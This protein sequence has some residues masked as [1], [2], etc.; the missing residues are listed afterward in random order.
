M[1]QIGRQAG[2]FLIGG[3]MEVCRMGYGAMRLTGEGVWGP[4][5]DREEA[6][7]VLRRAIELG[8]DLI[9]TADAYGPP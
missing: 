4:P 1:K 6:K 3:D 7:R 8:I 2:T 9:D 5:R